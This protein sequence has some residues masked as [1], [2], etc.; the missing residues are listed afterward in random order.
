[1][2]FY[3]F[4][5]IDGDY[6]RRIY[7]PD[8]ERKLTAVNG[9]QSSFGPVCGTSSLEKTIQSLRHLRISIRWLPVR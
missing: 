1:V 9:G 5:D 4:V 8:N 2:A 3:N 6:D 7:L